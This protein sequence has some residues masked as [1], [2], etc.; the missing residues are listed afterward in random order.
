[1]NATVVVSVVVVN[2]TVVVSVV[3]MNATVV[4]MLRCENC[5]ETGESAVTIICFKEINCCC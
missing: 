3:V 2:A 4:V 5:F 1:M